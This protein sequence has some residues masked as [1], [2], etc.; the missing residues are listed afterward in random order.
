MW[1]SE[2]IWV[3]GTGTE[4]LGVSG[5]GLR[6]YLRH[7]RSP[8][9]SPPPVRGSGCRVKKLFGFRVRVRNVFG[10]RLSA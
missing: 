6:F 5:F 4:F 3:S 1:G 9:E 2:F 10:F 8:P 7:P